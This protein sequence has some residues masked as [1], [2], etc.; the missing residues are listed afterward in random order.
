MSNDSSKKY[1]ITG[2]LFSSHIGY[3]GFTRVVEL[4]AEIMTKERLKAKQDNGHTHVHVI[5]DEI[6]LLESLDEFLSNKSVKIL[7]IEEALELLKEEND[8]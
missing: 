1:F 2:N 5:A 6:Q 8:G 3:G 7:S 4:C